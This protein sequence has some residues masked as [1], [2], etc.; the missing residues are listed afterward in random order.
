[1]LL[2]NTPHKRCPVHECIHA[3]LL[4]G[5]RAFRW[6]CNLLSCLSGW[7]KASTDQ[8]TTMIYFP[9]R[10]SRETPQT[11]S[12]QHLARMG[13]VFLFLQRLEELESPAFWFQHEQM[14]FPCHRSH[15]LV[16]KFHRKKIFVMMQALNKLQ[17]G[18][19]ATK[20]T[21]KEKA[22]SKW[23]SIFCWAVSHERTSA[24]KR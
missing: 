5:Q 9:L 4:S 13:H 14:A 20:P 8:L 11:H 3:Y 6:G 16:E 2:V 15:I 24:L 7:T 23:I 22:R 10:W 19:A 18:P 12:K 17:C 1:M 21:M